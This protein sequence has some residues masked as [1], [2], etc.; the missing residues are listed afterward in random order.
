MLTLLGCHPKSH[1]AIGRVL[2]HV[3][4]VVAHTDGTIIHMHL[5]PG[6]TIQPHQLLFVQNSAPFTWQAKSAWHQY[7]ASQAT[8]QDQRYGRRPAYLAALMAKSQSAESAVQWHQKTATRTNT[9]ESEGAT[10]PAAQDQARADLAMAQA[11]HATRQ[12]QAAFA[13]L[14]ERPD[15]QQAQQQMALAKR[16]NAHKTEWQLAQT[17]QRAKVL[18]HLGELYAA[19]GDRVHRLQPICTLLLPTQLI[20]ID[21][22]PAVI[23]HLHLGQKM[24]YCIAP[25][26]HTYHTATLQRIADHNRFTPDLYYDA[27]HAQQLRFQLTLKLMPDMW[28]KMHA[29]QKVVVSLPNMAA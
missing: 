26:A 9:L 17:E 21:V 13:K 6:Q 22:Q 25:C 7:Q 24:R 4:V 10:T 16:H 29:G 2:A 8:A 28:G 23:A 1:E 14:P 27:A 19:Q 11:D 18:G 3:M 12:S 5:Q 15:Q 20:A